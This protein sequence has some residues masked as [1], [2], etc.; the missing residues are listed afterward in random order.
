MHQTPLRYERQPGETVKAYAAFCVYRDLGAGRGLRDACRRFYGESVAKRGQIEQWSKQ[1]KW[2]ERAKAWDDELDRVNRE[3]QAKARKE[4]GERH[5]KVAVA[6][7]E[8]AIQRLK[9][10]K[11]E[12]LSSSD[13]IRYFV[14]AAKLERLSRG[15]PDSIEE[16][17]HSGTNGNPIRIFLE[18][19]IAEEKRLEA[20]RND[21][22]Q[23]DGSAPVRPGDP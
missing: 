4:M 17:R 11:P 13:L 7:Q 15:E 20:E 21:P 23:R 10:M 12:E 14:E 22:V 19:V 1:W 6:L 5:A 18:E 2:V 8:K 3:A 9:S 16:Q